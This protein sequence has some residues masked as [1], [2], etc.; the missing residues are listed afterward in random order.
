VTT[1]NGTTCTIGGSCS[2]AGGGGTSGLS[3]L[4]HGSA[5]IVYGDSISM[6]YGLASPSTTMYAYLMSQA[7]G[8]P[9]TDR[10]ISG[11]Q[12]CDIWPLQIN[13]YTATD[14]PVQAIANLYT[15][16]IGTN[17]VD[18]KHTGA[19]EAVYN[20]CDQAVLTFLATPRESKVLPGDAAF[21]VV[22]GS[23]SASAVTASGVTS[24]QMT[25]TGVLQAA[26][27]T[28]GE[29]IYVWSEIKD[30][31]SGSFTVSVD[32][33]AAHGPYSTTTTPAIATQTG[34][35]ESVAL[36]G[37]YAVAAGAHTVAFTWVSGTV[38]IVGVGSI[39]SAPYYNEPAIAVGQVPNQGPTGAASTPAAIAQYNTDVAANI[40]LVSGDGG[41]VRF[42]LDQ[43]YMF[44]TAAEMSGGAAPLHPGPLGHLHLAQAFEAGL[45]EASPSTILPFTFTPSASSTPTTY[46]NA[47]ITTVYTGASGYS[48]VQPILLEAGAL[49]SVSVGFPTIPTAGCTI[50]I[51]ILTGSGNSYALADSFPVTLAAVAGVQVFNA[52][53]A[54]SAR[55]VT[56]SEYLGVFNISGCE[57]VGYETSGGSPAYYYYSGTPTSTP[58]TYITGGNGS[59]VALSGTVAPS[60]VV[61]ATTNNVTLTG[62]TPAGHCAALNPDNS[63]AAANPA[64][65][66][67]K[68]TNQIT[69]TNAAVSGMSFDGIC[70]SN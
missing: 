54:Y 30:G 35:T 6:G 41:D 40:A 2:P 59:Q 43:N 65:V 57:G 20:T 18:V 36:S 31:T 4:T 37:R 68:T 28:T 3:R 55:N 21:T 34:T 62:M 51:D 16:M 22:S 19:Y 64:Y 63:T 56:A 42:V 48:I 1:I 25:A 17:D 32:G 44:A 50:Q 15:V 67:A 23:N 38:G 33:G 14:A 39:P 12:A 9:Y 45:Q 60:A 47:N 5:L 26:I 49:T 46:G 69:I 7:F 66:S 61:P 58:V 8:I 52:G 13:P 27:T 10:A 53:T 11:D 70:T 29:P 24:A